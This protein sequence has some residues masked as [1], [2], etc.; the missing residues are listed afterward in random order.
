[1]VTWDRPRGRAIFEEMNRWFKT[2]MASLYKVTNEVAPGALD[3]EAKDS[4]IAN[5]PIRH[6]GIAAPLDLSSSFSK[7]CCLH[8]RG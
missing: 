8:N 6:S 7:T 5:E 1:M 3:G 4:I 2:Q